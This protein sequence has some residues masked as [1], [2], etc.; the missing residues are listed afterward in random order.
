VIS[1]HEEIIY[2]E[3]EKLEENDLKFLLDGTIQY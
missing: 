3:E 1:G 2:N